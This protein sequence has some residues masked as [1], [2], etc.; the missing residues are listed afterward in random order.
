[1]TANT[2][3]S[4]I[5]NAL[6]AALDLTT[7]VHQTVN[8]LLGVIPEPKSVGSNSIEV[9]PDGVLPR[10]ASTSR[11]VVDQVSSA[12]AALRRLQDATDKA[13]NVTDA[14]DRGYIR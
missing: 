9:A 7:L 3:T 11:Y 10:M 1:M 13:E 14:T 8:G 5:Q 2:P 12:A 4:E 6:N